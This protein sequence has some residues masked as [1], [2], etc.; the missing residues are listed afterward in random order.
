MNQW[1]VL[2]MLKHT[3]RIISMVETSSTDKSSACNC[4]VNKD[5]VQMNV[6][7]NTALIARIDVLTS[8]QKAKETVLK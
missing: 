2:T 1:V 6:V 4:V 5:E 7:V 8:T 3:L